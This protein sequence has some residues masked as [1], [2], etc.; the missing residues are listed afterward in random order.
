MHSSKPRILVIENSIAVTGALQSI[1][2]SSKG[3]Q[4][5]FSFVFLFPQGSKATEYVRDLQFEAHEMKMME[6]RKNTSSLLLYLP[7]LLRNAISLFSFVKHQKIDLIVSNDFYNLLPSV[8]RVLG[9]KVPYICYVRFLPSKFPRR[10]VKF[11]CVLHR[12]YAH[13]TVAV[14]ES[15]LRE[16]PFK[17]RVIVIGNELPSNEAPFTSTLNYKSILY[18][19]NYIQGKG[20][21]LALESF[22][23]VARNH[24]QWKLRFVGGDMGL[25]KNKAFKESLIKLSK[26]LNLE[27]QV[28]WLHF[29]ENIEDEYQRAAF[30]LNFSESESFSMTV[31]EAMYYGRPVIATRSGGPAEI[32]D[33]NDSGILVD[34]KDVNAMANAIDY[35]IANPEKREHMAQRA[36]NS[37]RV[38]YSYENTIAKLGNLYHD[39]LNR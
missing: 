20:H 32:I 14:S 23:L 37:V 10:L 35:L 9:G 16:L 6:I 22:N 25:Q 15:V 17:E 26:R 24:P 38:K 12:R 28:E 31:L 2:R 33:Q 27:S 5:R 21:E 39:C 34:L 11:W 3:L 36:Y 4:N 7:T 1:L 13:T 29:S 18:P 30:V 8:Y 19:S